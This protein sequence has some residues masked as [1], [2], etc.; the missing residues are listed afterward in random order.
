MNF[1]EYHSQYKFFKEDF[2]PCTVNF[3]LTMGYIPENQNVKKKKQQHKMENFL[4][5]ELIKIPGKH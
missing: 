4:P 5:Q 1:L 3:R 2:A